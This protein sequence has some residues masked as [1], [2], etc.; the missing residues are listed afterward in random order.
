MFKTILWQIQKSTIAK[1]QADAHHT[2]LHASLHM[3][4][5]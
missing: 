1:E 3:A 2:I 5:L 4:T